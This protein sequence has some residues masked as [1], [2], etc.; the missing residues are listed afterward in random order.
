M[1]VRGLRGRQVADRG[2]AI[3]DDA[4]VGAEPRRAGA[5]DHAAVGDHDVE[6]ARLGGRPAGGQRG[7]RRRPA[8]GDGEHD[9][10]GDRSQPV[11]SGSDPRFAHAA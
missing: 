2:D 5:V 11:R 4:D 8:T 9:G 10:R 6:G 7:R 3:A 1:R